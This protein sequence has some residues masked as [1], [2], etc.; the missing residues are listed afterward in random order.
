ME[1]TYRNIEFCS[2]PETL[3]G[4]LREGRWDWLGVHKKSGFVLGSP[5]R[6]GV[7]EA[8]AGFKVIRADG[9]A[10]DGVR[11][12][13]DPRHEDLVEER[14]CADATEA[15]ALFVE[16][17]A[18]YEAQ[19]GPLLLKVQLIRDGTVADTAFVV[20][21]PPTYGVWRPPRA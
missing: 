13:T 16:L 6:S 5:T 15:A 9:K 14:W 3:W 20:N 8:H 19:E 1:P 2:N 10:S 12:M 18:G 4:K 21:D 11:V 17:V 7:M